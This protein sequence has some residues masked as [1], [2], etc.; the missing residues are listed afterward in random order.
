MKVGSYSNLLPADWA[1]TRD[2][3]SEAIGRVERDAYLY[4]AARLPGKAPT[5]RLPQPMPPWAYD[6]AVELGW[7]D[8]QGNVT[9][10]YWR[11]RGAMR[12]A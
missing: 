4:T 11:E 6:A 9:E 1:P 7:I 3:I 2:S 8:A 5:D 10:R 12:H